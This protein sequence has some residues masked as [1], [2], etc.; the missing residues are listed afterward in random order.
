MGICTYCGLP[1]FEDNE[2]AGK[3][4]QE[5]C[6]VEISASLVSIFEEMDEW[7][8]GGSKAY[9]QRALSGVPQ[10]IDV[11]QDSYGTH[12]SHKVKRQASKGRIL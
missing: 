7:R 1:V 10:Q 8:L 3:N 5:C 12:A 4:E 6:G 2:S 9:R 11:E